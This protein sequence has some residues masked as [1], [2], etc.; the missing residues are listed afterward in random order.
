MLIEQDEERYFRPAYFGDGWIGI[1]LDL[2][3]NDWDSL[4]DWIMR[5]WRNVAPRKLTALLDAM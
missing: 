3:D 1:R 5:S 2:G 4:G